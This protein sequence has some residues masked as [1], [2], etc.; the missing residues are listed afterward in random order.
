MQQ[1]TRL[2]FLISCLLL[3]K[4]AAFAQSK[5]DKINTLI[6]D[7]QKKNGFNGNILVAQGK[8]ILANKAFGYAN[9]EWAIANQISTKFCLASVTKPFTAI[10]VMQLVEEGKI[11]LDKT[12]ADYLP[13]CKGEETRG[14]TIHQLLSHTSGIPDFIGADDTAPGRELTVDSLVKSLSGVKPQ[15]VPGS[16]FRYANSTYI[17]LSFI[18]EQVTGK[19][20]SENQKEYIFNKAGMDDSG[21]EK[22]G[23]IIKHN[24]SGYIEKDGVLS[25]A[26]YGYLTPIFKGAGAMYSTVE[27][28]YKW[29]QALHSEVLLSD[30]AKEKMFTVVKEPY[31]YGWFV[32]EI[33]QVGKMYS[34]EGG[35]GGFSSLVVRIP[36][37][38]YFIAMLSNKDSNHQM[39][40]EL[41]KSIIMS[42]ESR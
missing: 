8:T 18:I 22:S 10:R 39:D 5:A 24:A 6:E 21:C 19:S 7:F 20:F 25:T 28:L 35:F 30:K 34:H 32:R 36:S 17:L 2:F 12:I 29:D 23:E 9:L 15:F 4:P 13:Q 27:D 11:H 26:P 38:K 42:L 14:V 3:V 1:S 16:Q 31:A 40:K 37:K 41:V 33:P